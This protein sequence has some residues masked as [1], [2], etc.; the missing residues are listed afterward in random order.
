MQTIWKYDLENTNGKTL[1]LPAGAVI[2]CV[3]TQFGD[4][5]LWALVDEELTTK[6]PRHIRII[7]TGDYI[8]PLVS[9]ARYK[10]GRAHV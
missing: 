2:L 1:M 9:P 4:P 3:K 10:I 7:G 5:Q 6:E 8:D